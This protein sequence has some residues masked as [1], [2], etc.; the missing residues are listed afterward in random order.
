M[1][2]D[3]EHV[4]GLEASRFDRRQLIVG[5]G[6]AA[7]M[8][9]AAL[10]AC[11]SDSK[12]AASAASVAP[13]VTDAATPVTD[14]ATPVT[15]V[16]APV[17][18]AATPAI[19]AKSAFGGLSKLVA[20]DGQMTDLMDFLLFDVQVSSGESGTLRFDVL[21]APGEPNAVLVYE[22]YESQAAFQVHMSGAPF[23]KYVADIEPNVIES[24]SEVVPFGTFTIPMSD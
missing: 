20:K 12:S 22:M 16:A 17:T 4:E 23:K 1:K 3:I 21:P 6:A 5:G 11:G 24:S 2:V 7:A 14:A 15:E 8:A 10:A 19:K 13:A 18:D 9:A